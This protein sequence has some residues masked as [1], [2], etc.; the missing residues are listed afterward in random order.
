MKVRFKNP[1]INELIIG[2]YFNPPIFPL[3]SEHIGLLWSRFRDDFPKVEQREPFFVGA[4]DNPSAQ[5]TSN[6]FPFMPRYWFVS[7]DE[8]NL[9]QIQKDAFLLNWRKREAEYPHFDERLKP[10]FVDYLSKFKK[11]LLE[12][13]GM[14]DI[15]IGICELTYIDV[16]EPCDFWQGPQDTSRLIPSFVTP[17]FGIETG[18]ATAFNCVYHHKAEPELQLRTSIQTGESTAEPKSPRLILEFKALGQPAIAEPLDIVRWYDRAH[19]AII[20]QFLSMTDKQIQRTYW[21]PE[22]NSQ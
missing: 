15:E 14:S 6:E 10:C 16:I 18:S 17:D 19:D 12:E 8:V 4:L 11:F 22:E 13:F 3:R 2:V 20:A 9:I 1:P 7:E 21:V 5:I